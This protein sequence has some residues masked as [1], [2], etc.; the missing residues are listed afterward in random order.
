MATIYFLHGK[1]SGP[2]GTKIRAL[3]RVAER[4]G[5]R[6]VSPDMQDEPDPEQ[7]VRRL[8][9]EAGAVAPPLVLAGSS[10]G[11]YVAA[12]ASAVLR[13]RGLFL[14]APAIG[15]SG[16]ATADP[17]PVAEEM[18]IVHGWDDEVVPLQP[19]FDFARRQQCPFCLLPDGHNLQAQVPA[20]E[21]LFRDFLIRCLE[22]PAMRQAQRLSACL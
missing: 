18:I 6:V 14:M 10:M 1:E 13:P 4:F 9:E 21:C 19:V 22:I 2:W 7:R 17:Q 20:L 5:C 8:V 12:A 3:A 15:L 16:Y 11:G